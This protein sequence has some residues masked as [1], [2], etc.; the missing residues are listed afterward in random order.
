MKDA[1]LDA[2]E[3]RVREFLDRART[4]LGAIEMHVRE[5]E[6]APAL[7]QAS[8]AYA[9]FCM[10]A[11]DYVSGAQTGRPL[12]RRLAQRLLELRDELL[13]NEA[14][15]SG[16]GAG[17]SAQELADLAASAERLPNAV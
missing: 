13:P 1:A 8:R 15:L 5:T 4:T 17:P 12:P 3:A 16:I 11:R 9:R 10:H 7:M 6:E 2:F 14:A